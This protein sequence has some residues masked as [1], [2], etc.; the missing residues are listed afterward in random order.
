MNITTLYHID[1][2]FLLINNEKTVTKN[3]HKFFILT[4]AA[5]HMQNSTGTRAYNIGKLSAARQNLPRGACILWKSAQNK[6]MNKKIGAFTAFMIIFSAILLHYFAMYNRPPINISYADCAESRIYLT[7]DDGPSDR[8]TPL[9]LDTLKQEKVKAT[10]F[11]VGRSVN[12][13][14]K[15]LKRM[16]DEG[17][18]IGVHSYS[19]D[20]KSIYASPAALLEDIEKCND[21]IESVTGERSTIYRFPG[22]SYNIAG[23][24]VSAVLKAGYTY[25]DWNASLRDA[26]IAGATPEQLLEEAKKSSAGKTKVVLL[27]HDGTSKTPTA[28][29]LKSVI[30]YFRNEGYAFCAL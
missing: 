8:V 24:L 29:A 17:H 25:V 2:Y 4:C 5:K 11:I 26:E 30:E 9:I 13:R 12:G 16:H 20:Y 3:L 14:E 21:V 10:F 19:H 15:I 18:A 1:A 6:D 22:G 7:F 23:N 27:C 28:K